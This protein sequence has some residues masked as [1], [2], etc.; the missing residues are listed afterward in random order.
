MSLVHFYTFLY[1]RNRFIQKVQ[2]LRLLYCMKEKVLYFSDKIC[3]FI[4][5]NNIYKIKSHCRYL[6]KFA[7]TRTFIRPCIIWSKNHFHFIETKYLCLC[8]LIIKIFYIMYVLRD[9]C[10]N[11]IH[12]NGYKNAYLLVGCIISVRFCWF[13]RINKIIAFC[14]T[15]R[16]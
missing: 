8:F 6:R 7:Y 13:E 4:P 11:I 15:D 3:I 16:A 1:G 14:I 9:F 12:F 10:K 2:T 5:A